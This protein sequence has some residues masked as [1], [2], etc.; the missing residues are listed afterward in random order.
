VNPDALHAVWRNELDAL[1]LEVIRVERLLKGLD[2]V[3]AEQWNPAPVPGPI[4]TDLV[5]RAQQL[6]DRQA[7]ARAM[8]Q[9]ALTAAQRHLAYGERV[10]D[11]T[12]SP[13]AAPVYVDVE[14]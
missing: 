1:E 9:D 2:A 5:P 14:A 11:A 7:A 13:G 4:P 12:S 3:S 6:L 10:S 8:L